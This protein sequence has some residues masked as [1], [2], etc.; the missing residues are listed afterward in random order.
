MKK[1]F[2]LVLLTS[3]VWQLFGQSGK[4]EWRERIYAQTDKHL[5]LAGEPILVKILTTDERQIPL[6]FSKIAYAELV[7][8]TMAHVQIKV[9]LTN[10]TGAGRMLLPADLPT[11]YYRLIAYTQFMR[12][13]GMDV[14][15]EKNITVVNT[16]QS[17]YYPAESE[18]PL[19]NA[20]IT[21]VQSATSGTV[22]LQP[23]K[24]AY[25]KRERGELIINGLPENMHTLSVS[26]TG[27]DF[28]PIVVPDE[29]F[30]KNL[31]K[32]AKD[33]SGAY[34]P[35]YE[36][37]VITGKI[38]DN[39]TETVIKGLPAENLVNDAVFISA[40]IAFPGEKIRF[41]AG[42]KNNKDEIQF[43]TTGISGMKELATVLFHSDERYRMDIQS[44]FVSRY[45]PKSMPELQIDSAHYHM[46]LARSVALQVYRY[47]SEES[48]ENQQIS[49]PHFDI[50]PTFSYLLDEYTR[51]TTMREVFIEFIAGARFRRRDGKQE[52]QVY[53]RRGAQQEYGTMP[54]VLLDGLPITDHELIYNYD[55]LSVEHINIYFG[56]CILGGL[57]FDGII[58]L[59]TYRRLHADLN[60]ARSTQ[61]LTY[62]GPQP[63]YRL[64]SPDY[65]DEKNRQSRM[66]DGRHTLLWNP[67]VQTEGKTS[68]S[69]PF[70][71]S[72]LTG[73]FQASMEGMT[74]D[75]KF[76]HAT[77]L[78]NVK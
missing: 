67:D 30:R 16:F 18:Q 77:V 40:A 10:G 66:P 7:A 70:Y 38:V 36:G 43:I 14:F 1:Y 76:I 32:P 4:I 8:D 60:L 53:T 57:Q 46:L 72:D 64:Y 23:D 50:T 59:I 12:N 74:K 62:E 51:F 11:G 15:F 26:V 6:V 42:K 37:H 20:A 39:Q 78:F 31:S 65:S 19:S 73:D 44:P 2:C 68:I 25:T 27:K 69:L 17:G 9:E 48:S 49:E 22:S 35:E 56:P 29:S 13:E 34:L 63:V 71:T 3:I 61:V 55:P 45:A 75:G 58:E 41:F 47:F 52:L 54:L 5:Y 28:A 33:L 24:P 21:Q